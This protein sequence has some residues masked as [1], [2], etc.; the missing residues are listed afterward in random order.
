MTWMPQTG[1]CSARC[2]SQRVNVISTT[3]QLFIQYA[4]EADTLAMSFTFLA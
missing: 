2:A 4:L 1:G 3:W